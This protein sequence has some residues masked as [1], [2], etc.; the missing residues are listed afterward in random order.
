MGE[1]V[2]KDNIRVAVRGVIVDEEWRGLFA[3]IWPDPQ[4]LPDG[5]WQVPGGG[6]EHGETLEQG[7][8]REL[9]EECGATLG[10]YGPKLCVRTHSLPS[11]E[12]DGHENHIYLVRVDADAARKLPAP[13]FSEEQLQ[14]EGIDELRWLSF[15]EIQNTDV[16]FSPRLLPELL[17]RARD[18]E[19][20]EE[21]VHIEGY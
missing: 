17:R 2:L 20:F 8:R 7:L 10:E 18:G 6:V 4:R 3:R 19:P 12:F 9:M 11:D 5:L 1:Q 15:D 21:P 13:T 16:P 14:A